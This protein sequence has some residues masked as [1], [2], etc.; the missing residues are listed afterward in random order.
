M[1]G[2]PKAIQDARDEG[3]NWSEQR[4]ACLRQA[5]SLLGASDEVARDFEAQGVT[6]M[7][8]FPLHVIAI[9][10]GNGPW[11][12]SMKLARPDGV[13]EAAWS[14]SLLVA[15]GLAMMVE[16]WAFGLED[17]GDGVLLMLLPEDL[18]D[19]QLLAGRLQGMLTMCK[20]VVAGADAMRSMLS[21]VG[22]E[23]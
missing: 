19:A 20:S 5:A 11:V 17:D 2:D 4:R 22:A 8:G 3:P 15:N 23:A 13:S 9:V 6:L 21:G 18:L 16:D 12:A 7:E 10:Q 1:I 14:E